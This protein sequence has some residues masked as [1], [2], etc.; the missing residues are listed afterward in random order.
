M[1][2]VKRSWD[3]L[4]PAQRKAAAEAIIGH[5]QNEGREGIGLI[6]AEDVLD[7]FLQSAGAA[8]YNKGV[9][10]AK[11]CLK[12]RLGDIELDIEVLKR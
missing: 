6:A 5:F 7:V 9:E 8:L 1:K 3:I 2:P 4:S 11:N 12:G 10:D